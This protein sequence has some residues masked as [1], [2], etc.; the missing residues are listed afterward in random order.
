M[1]RINIGFSCDSNYSPYLGVSIF[2]ILSNTKSPIS[3]YILDLG[4]KEEDK[5]KLIDLCENKGAKITFLDQRKVTIFN[6]LKR[7]EKISIAAYFKLLIPQIVNCNKIITIDVDTIIEG[8]INELWNTSIEGK[9]M[10]AIPS[11]DIA[12]ANNCKKYLGIPQYKDY[13]CSGVMLIDCIKYKKNDILKKV[14]EFI[15]KNPEKIIIQEQDGLNYIMQDNWFKLP[16]IWNV[17]HLFYY[18]STLLRKKL[19]KQVDVIRKNPK[20]IHFTVR[21]WLFEKVHPLRNR[22]WFYA[23][24]SPWKDINYKDITIKTIILKIFRFIIRPVPIEIKLKV[25]DKI[26]NGLLH[27]GLN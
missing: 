8:D 19:G 27:M 18:H 3:F 15:S 20:L 4:I 7:G 9:I 23:R 24:R 6:S 25:K 13:F 21:P 11:A 16:Y 17:N 22:F 5:K 1:H 12:L 2:S 26:I 10:G 14:I